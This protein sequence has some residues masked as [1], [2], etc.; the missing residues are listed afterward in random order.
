GARAAAA[1]G[2]P[3]VAG[4][5]MGLRARALAATGRPDSALAVYD[6]AI[7]RWRDPGPLLTELRFARAGLLERLGRWPL[8]S[9]GYRAL[10]AADPSHPLAVLSLQ[11][12]VEHHLGAGEGEMARSE[13]RQADVHLDELLATDH[14]PV[15]RRS[16]LEVRA[17]IALAL[18][19]A[20][21]AESLYTLLWH[22]EPD[23]SLAQAGA[24]AAARLVST[25]PGAAAA[26]ALEDTLA[27]RARNPAVRRAAAAAR[28]P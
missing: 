10:V 21:A 13:A 22:R 23:D 11:R 17:G 16:V 27:W 9:A 8:A 20:A 1:S 6:A 12:V 18:G 28:T 7:A 15:V 19:E 2:D 25:G 14:D 3:A 5:A 4:P 24:L 26:A